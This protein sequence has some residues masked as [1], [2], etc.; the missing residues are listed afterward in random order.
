MVSGKYVVSSSCDVGGSVVGASVAGGA[1]GD[2]GKGDGGAEVVDGEGAAVDGG[3][4]VVD[5]EG[6]VVDGEGT[7][8]DGEGAAVELVVDDTT[9]PAFWGQSQTRRLG[10]KW[11]SPE[12][13]KEYG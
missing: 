1:V 2:G 13:L 6:S 12:Q 3:G 10:L 4:L 9:H 11:R 8:V 7:V 5:G